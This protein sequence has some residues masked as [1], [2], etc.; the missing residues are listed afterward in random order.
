MTIKAIQLRHAV[1]LARL[2]NFHRAAEE[3]QISQA[4]LSRSIHALE[5]ALGVKLFDRLASGTAPTRFGEALVER[6]AR[7][8]AGIDDLEREIGLMR[9]LDSG[10]L[11]IGAGPY[12]MALSVMRALS[13]LMEARPQLK[14]RAKQSDWHA[15]TDAVTHQRVD[16]A[17]AELSYAREL[18]SLST[19]LLGEHRLYFVARR[20]HP[21]L[22]IDAPVLDDVLKY[23]VAGTPV[24]ERVASQF[25]GAKVGTYRTSRKS[26][27]RPSIEVD[28][29]LQAMDILERSDVVIATPLS[30]AADRLEAGRLDVV[31]L[32]APWF[33]LS[34]GAIWIRDRSLSPAALAFIDELDAVER[35]LK[36]RECELAERWVPGLGESG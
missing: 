36:Q 9:G 28:D 23:P 19:R 3:L 18:D 15:A 13:R 26:P 33:K 25:E 16:L 29:L 7:I 14:I 1:C 32:V 27:M 5:S 21:L 22:K 2:G 6:G 20:G 8:I 34:Y 35:E 12:P 10:S 11:A 31:R 4:G 30:L 17:I 24:P